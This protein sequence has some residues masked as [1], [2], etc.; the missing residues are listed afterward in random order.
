[1]QRGGNFMRISEIEVGQICEL[2]VFGEDVTV[3]A[4]NLDGTVTVETSVGIV[5][6]FPWDLDA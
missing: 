3:L 5:R 6:T 1:M 4:I 2:R